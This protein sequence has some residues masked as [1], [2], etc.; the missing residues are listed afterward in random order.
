MMKKMKVLDI[1][2]LVLSVILVFGTKFVFHACEVGENIMSCHWAEQ[3]VFGVGLVLMVQALGLLL[4]NKSD[5]RRGIHF[6]M[7]P[8]AILAFFL[9][10]GLIHLCMMKDMRCHTTMRPA[11]MILSILIAICAIVSTV[12]DGKK[13]ES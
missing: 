7:I 9:P 5:V 11:I 2:L 8:T 3:T 10:G 1:V 4:S 6:A 13:A 12:L